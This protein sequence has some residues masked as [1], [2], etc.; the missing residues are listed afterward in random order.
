MLDKNKVYVTSD[1]HLFHKNIIKYCNRP[2]SFDWDGVRQMNE[3]IIKAFDE[4]PDDSIIIN[5]GDICLNSQVSF[6]QL[7]CFID[8]MK[9]GNKQLWIIMGNHDRELQRYI[10]DQDYE[11]SYDLLIGLGFDK[12]FEFPI[13][14]G[15]CLFSHEPV[16]L[17]PGSN[18]INVYGHT[19]DVLIDKDYFN[20]DCE[21]WAM[22][23]RVK[24][25]GIT[26]QKN[27]DIDTSV[28]PLGKLVDVDNYVNVCWD[29]NKRFIPLGE[30]LKS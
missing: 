24:K 27:L 3:D 15:D 17:K 11:T 22:M 25:E 1:L 16:Y 8:R 7:K 21:N 14:I 30:L 10:K 2:Y 12:V 28:K 4:L 26:E 29:A 9:K 20:R 18:L 19:H 23:E 5:N 13:L 6:G